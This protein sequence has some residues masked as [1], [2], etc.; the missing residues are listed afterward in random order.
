MSRSTGM[1]ES[2]QARMVHCE[3]RQGKAPSLRG[4]AGDAAI[5]RRR[6]ERS[7]GIQRLLR[8]ARKDMRR[9]KE[10]PRH[11]EEPQATRQSPTGVPS[12]AKGSRDCFATLEMTSGDMDTKQG[13]VHYYA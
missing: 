11:C 9:R 13:L 10:K 12:A 7:E 8:Y 4:A 6:P 5:R 2:D 3:E 1:C